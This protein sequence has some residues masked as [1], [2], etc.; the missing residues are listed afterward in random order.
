MDN[1]NNLPRKSTQVALEFASPLATLFPGVGLPKTL[2]SK[3]LDREARTLLRAV[4]L[5]GGKGDMDR[6]PLSVIRQT[7]RV[8]CLTLGNRPE[9]ASV[10]ELEIEGPGGPIALRIFKPRQTS[11]LLPAFMWYFGGGFLIGDLDTIDPVCRTVAQAAGCITIAMRYRLSPEYDISASREDAYAAL[12]WIAANGAS[13]GIDTS[14]LAIGGDSAGGNLTA[15]I[16]Q[17]AQ[18]RG[19]PALK[20]QVMIYPATE[21]V[22]KF[23]SFEENMEGNYVLDA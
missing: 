9:M 12:E 14:R 1:K 11:E 15:V 13:V 7:L 8:T 5:S 22:Q 17:E 21:M 18:R 19:G 20:M 4:N 2:R 6:I 16:A 10:T 3:E 23:P